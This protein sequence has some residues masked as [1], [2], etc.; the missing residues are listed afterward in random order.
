MCDQKSHRTVKKV[1]ESAR[2]YIFQDFIETGN[3]K[4]KK[5]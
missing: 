3:K 5:F 4:I 1:M 2:G